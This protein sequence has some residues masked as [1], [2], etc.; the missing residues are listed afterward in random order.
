MTRAGRGHSFD[1]FK[2][3]N[4]QSVYLTKHPQGWWQHVLR[5]DIRRWIWRSDVHL[6]AR[7]DM[8]GVR[9]GNSYHITTAILKRADNAAV[10]E[11]EDDDEEPKVQPPLLPNATGAVVPKVTRDQ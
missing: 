8:Q 11:D 5:E 7:N 10:R 9:H 1:A 2:R 3:A 4:G 6:L